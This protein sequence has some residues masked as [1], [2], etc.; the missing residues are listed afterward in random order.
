ML[1]ADDSSVLRP[2]LKRPRLR[3]PLKFLIA[4]TIGLGSVIVSSVPAIGR[5]A[6]PKPE[7]VLW[8]APEHA[9][10]AVGIYASVAPGTADEAY[11]AYFDQGAVQVNGE[12]RLAG[13]LVLGDYELAVVDGRLVVED[14][15]PALSPPSAPHEKVTRKATR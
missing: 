4:I 1:H 2:A 10:Q 3:P 11:A 14:N 15:R 9:Q 13:K 5:M 12:L 8:A 6:E 7:V